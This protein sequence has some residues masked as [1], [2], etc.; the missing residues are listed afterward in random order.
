M[1]QCMIDVTNLSQVKIGDEVVLWG[2]QG[3]EEITIEEIAGKIGTINYEI[4]HMPD[5]KRVPK[6]FIKNGRP[7]KVKTMLGKKLL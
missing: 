1:D 3:H 4:V 5:K 7:W 6:L 2:K